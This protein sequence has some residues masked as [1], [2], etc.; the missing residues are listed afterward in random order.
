MRMACFNAAKRHATLR[1]LT[2]SAWL[3]YAAPCPAQAQPADAR[4]QWEAVQLVVYKSQRRMALYRFGNFEKEFPVVLGLSPQGRKRHAHD[5][6]TPEG[7]YRIAGKRRDDRWQYFL[8]IDYPNGAD[9][10]AYEEEARSG[11]IPDENG[12]PFEIGGS[13]GIH[14]NDRADDQAGGEDWTKGC[15]ALRKADIAEVA[16][17]VPVGTPVWIVE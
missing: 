14:G 16:A 5:A 4:P 2:A 3:A 11:R 10:A 1:I 6:R 17:S 13:L 9:R 7:H 15:V 12:K 8:S